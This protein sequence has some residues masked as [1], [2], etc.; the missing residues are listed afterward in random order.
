MTTPSPFSAKKLMLAGCAMAASLFAVSIGAR[1]AE[2]GLALTSINYGPYDDPTD[3]PDGLAKGPTE[4]FLGSLTPEKRKEFEDR[5]KRAGSL[6]AYL[7]RVMSERRTASGKDVCEDPTGVTDPAMPISRAKSSFGMSLDNG[8][9]N[10]HCAHDKFQDASG[11]PAIDNQ[12]ARLTACIKSV[13]KSDNNRNLSEDAAIKMGK[14]ITLLRITNVTS[15][16]ESDDV[17]V[18]IYKSQSELIKD[19]TGAPLP[20]ATMKAADNQPL[21]HAVTHGKIVKGLLLT[22]PVDVHI[23]QPMADAYIRGAR[24]AINIHPDGQ[25]EGMVAGY[26]DNQSF[27]DSWARNSGTQDLLGYSCPALY[28]ALNQ[29][30]DGYKDPATGHCTAISAA[31]HI[32]AIRSFIA[33][34]KPAA[35]S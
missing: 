22:D 12:L 15:L 20:D 17:T 1:A 26:Y 25:A 32:K 14:N 21:Y 19:G 6:A 31:L 4:I 18:E 5:D 30:A 8:D 3:C 11:Q 34:P 33:P 35:S 10:S 7:T 13:R 27:W 29:L 9:Q 28:T 24:F 23:L 16:D 2:F